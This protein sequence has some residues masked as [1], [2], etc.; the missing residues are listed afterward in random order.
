MI[1]TNQIKSEKTPILAGS[2]R[3]ALLVALVILILAPLSVSA[4]QKQSIAGDYVGTLGPL[5]VALHLQ[6]GVAG[7]VTGTLDS[8]DRGAIG[9]RCS[10]FHVDGESISFS[11]PAVQGM[12]KGTVAADGTLN[13]TWE[14]GN[15]VPLI[16]ARDTATQTERASN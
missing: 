9:I 16:F 3:L 13:G 7:R 4:Q 10:N 8:P 15:Q 14:Q 1:S 6:V 11:I 12:W 5:H 2:G